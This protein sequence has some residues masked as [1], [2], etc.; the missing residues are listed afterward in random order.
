MIALMSSGRMFWISFASFLSSIA[1]ELP[2]APFEGHE[3]TFRQTEVSIFCFPSPWNPVFDSERALSLSYHLQFW[4]VGG[5]LEAM[6]RVSCS[7]SCLFVLQTD[8]STTL[9]RSKEKWGLARQELN[10]S[11]IGTSR[12]YFHSIVVVSFVGGST[13][14][15]FYRSSWFVAQWSCP[16]RQRA[17][18]RVRRV[19]IFSQTDCAG[20]SDCLPERNSSTSPS[21]SSWIAHY[22][23][24]TQAFCD[25]LCCFWIFQ[26]TEKTTGTFL[27]W[28][29]TLHV[30]FVQISHIHLGIRNTWLHRRCHCS[31]HCLR[32]HQSNI[33]QPSHHAVSRISHPPSTQSFHEQ[34]DIPF[35]APGRMHQSSIDSFWSSC[36]S[37]TMPTTSLCFWFAPLSISWLSPPALYLLARSWC[38]CHSANLHRLWLTILWRLHAAR[39]ATNG[40]WAHSVK[41]TATLPFALLF[42]F[43]CSLW[44]SSLELIFL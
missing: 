22:S 5:S 30:S 15:P 31:S 14:P 40:N 25:F 27:E 24:V 13:W 33:L 8:F 42:S 3:C 16:E 17:A 6:K 23:K 44:T 35:D 28:L 19:T 20:L 26:T 39:V 4:P 1:S 34:V 32:N 11:L 36:A 37:L 18:F 43:W 12:Y 29:E 9:A 21:F 10:H 38:V 7:D 2:Y 41:Q